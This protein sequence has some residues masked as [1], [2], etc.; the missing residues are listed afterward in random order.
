MRR[1]SP[2]MTSISRVVEPPGEGLALDEELDLEAREEHLVEGPYD[3]LVLTDR[4]NAHVS[5]ASRGRGPHSA[6]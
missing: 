5:Q 2:T 6:G 1:G 4:E 3:Q